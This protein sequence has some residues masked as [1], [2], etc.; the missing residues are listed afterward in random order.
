MCYNSKCSIEIKS[1][2]DGETS[3]VSANGKVIKEP[4][5]MRF[6]YSLDGDECTLTVTDSEVVQT[7]RGEH[8]IKLTFKKGEKTECLLGSGLFSGTVSVFTEDFQYSICSINK[9]LGAVH[10]FMLTLNYMLEEQ[11]I[12]INFSAKF[13]SRVKK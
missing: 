13:T 2:V 10:I 4:S 11:K 8:N 12:K 5:E 6:D 7:R 3:V 9:R 1:T